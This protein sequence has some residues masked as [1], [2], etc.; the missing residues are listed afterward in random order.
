MHE[1]THLLGLPIPSTNKA[2]L[3]V[4]IFHILIALAAVVVGVVA[5]LSEKT[6]GRHCKAGRIYFYLMEAS[7]LLIILLSVMRWPENIHLLL[8]GTLAFGCAYYGKRNAR[9]ANKQ[10]HTMLMGMSYIFLI[11]GFYV[12]NG[13]NLPFWNLFPNWFFYLFPTLVGLPIIIRTI[14]K[15][16]LNRKFNI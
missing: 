10:M 11:T 7:F 2:F 3:V 16:P 1:T 9:K 15:H 14:K 4:V 12:D 5:M 6:S 13:K 8:I